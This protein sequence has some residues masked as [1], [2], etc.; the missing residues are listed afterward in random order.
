MNQTS[1][2]DKMSMQIALN[3]HEKWDGSG[4]PGK[5]EN[6]MQPDIRLGSPKKQN[7]IPLP[8]RIVA[9]ADVYDALIS[10]RSY[11]ES[12]SREKALETIDERCRQTF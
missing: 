11:K 1:S 8:A 7:E 3:H 2:L 12:W 6:I 9:L 4:Y 10:C 5:I